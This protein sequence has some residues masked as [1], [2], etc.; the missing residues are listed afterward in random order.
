MKEVVTLIAATCDSCGRMFQEFRGDQEAVATES[1]TWR[2]SE[3]DVDLCKDKCLPGV[4]GMPLG[5]LLR[6][7][8]PRVLPVREKVVSR[9]GPDKTDQRERWA[10]IYNEK[11]EMFDCPKCDV[12]KKT[13]RGVAMHFFNEHKERL[14]EYLLRKAS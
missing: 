2:G 13:G 12:E 7:S 3:Y 6:I 10:A 5:E 8:R 4:E 14:S 1:W 9:R 11:T